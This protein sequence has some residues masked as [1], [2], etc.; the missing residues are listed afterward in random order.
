MVSWISGFIFAALALV[1]AARAETSEFTL[2]NGLRLIVKEDHRAPTVVQQVWY[3]AGSMD[4][5]PGTTGVA[6]VLEHMMFK[7]T[8]R[9][10]PEE[11]SRL[12]AEA[13][14]R[15]NAFTSTDYTVY[16]EQ[17]HRDRLP[18]VMRLEADRMANLAIRPEEF[19]REIKVVME[20]RRL[21][22]EDQPRAL[23]DENLLATAFSAHPYKSP[24]IGWMQDLQN[25]DWKDAQAWYR[26]WYAPNNATVVVVGDVDPGQVA[27]WAKRYY[28]ALARRAIPPR[29]PQSE[30]VQRGMRRVVLKAPAELAYVRFG[31]KA[32]ALRDPAK[33]WEPFALAVL[34]KVLGGND[35]ARLNQVLVR[36]RRI[37]TSAGAE[38]ELLSRG[39]GMVLLNAAAAQGHSGSELES[40]LREIA[41]RVAA[42]GVTAEELQ[43]AKVQLLA[44]LVYRRDSFFA[45]AMEIGELES[46]GL[47]FRDAERIPE[48]IKAVSAGQV[49]SVAA[50]Y[51]VDDA[52]TVAVLDPQ[53]LERGAPAH[54]AP[55][56]H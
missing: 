3:R 36:E 33:D 46:S 1:S 51:L 8:R 55:A 27:A 14:G 20:E 48:G 28:G 50:K 18:F 37:A 31:Y 5:S 49:Q 22:T 42:Q 13:G 25:M 15:D 41:A 53:P 45:Q 47:S 9:V 23:L 52:L 56:A 6:H 10:G 39:P 38:Y 2:A 12:V 30:P 34:V 54:T 44:Q 32:P 40:A 17:V 29:K 26:S 35:A 7:G 43:R 21:S 24:T 16:H 11:F 19:A 4:E